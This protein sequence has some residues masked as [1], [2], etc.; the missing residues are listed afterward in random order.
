MTAQSEVVFL[1]MHDVFSWLYTK[2][3]EQGKVAAFLPTQKWNFW[4]S[5]GSG[6]YPSAVHWNED[7]SSSS[8]V[9]DPQDAVGVAVHA[10]LVQYILVGSKSEQL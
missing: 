10:P 3:A 9:V 1:R 8:G 6:K 5:S 2:F 4:Q 7:V